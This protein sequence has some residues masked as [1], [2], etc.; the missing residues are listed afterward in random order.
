V[1][2]AATASAKMIVSF[3]MSFFSFCEPGHALAAR[4]VPRVLE[5]KMVLP[6]HFGFQNKALEFVRESWFYA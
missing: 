3:F 5:R 1:A 4:I 6:K 2:S